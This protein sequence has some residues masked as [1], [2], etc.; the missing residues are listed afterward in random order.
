MNGAIHNFEIYSKMLQSETTPY[1]QMADA[2]GIEH[3][4]PVGIIGLISPWNFPLLL[5]CNKLAPAIICG[6]CVVSKPSEI[7]PTTA[8]LVSKILVKILPPGVVNV[9]HGYGDRAGEP[10]VKSPITR[11]ISFTGGTVTGSRISSIAAPK[12]KKLQLELGGKNAAIVFNDC[13]LD[14]TVAGVASASFFNTGQVCC[15]GS[16]ILIQKNIA[17]KF[18]NKLKEYVSKNLTPNIG[19]PL[20]PKTVLGPLVSSQ[21]LKKVRSYLELAKKEGGK[22]ILGGRSG[23]ELTVNLPKELRNG[24]F[25]EPTIVTGLDD[26]C[27][28][29]MEE[30]FGP[31]ATV[32]VFDTEEDAI[33]IANQVNYGLAA[34]I[35]TSDIRR[36]Q[37][38]ARDLEAGSVWINCY[39][40][41]DDRMPFGGFKDSGVLREGGRHSIDFYT[42][43][44][45]VK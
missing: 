23:K 1:Y 45:S 19:N 25:F 38:V 20:D 4:N 5:F 41:Q 35:W 34:S 24:N 31:I 18:I 16:R 22:I 26:K 29:A 13:Y 37:R 21:H 15:S 27:R 7:S 42:E 9:V 12:L 11:A 39:L 40:Y 6:N 10:I 43:I 8:Y 2:V 33:R 14:E 28:C 44:K 30:I 3:R 36:G 32:H 17:N